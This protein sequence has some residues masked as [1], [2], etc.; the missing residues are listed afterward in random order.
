MGKIADQN[1]NLPL[2]W[3]QNGVSGPKVVLIS[4]FCCTK[5]GGGLMIRI[6]GNPRQLKQINIGNMPNDT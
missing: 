3:T 6:K 5:G 4:G 1:K 2:K